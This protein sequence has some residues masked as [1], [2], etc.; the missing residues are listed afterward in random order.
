[1]VASL[2]R[3]W[4][5]QVT[6][7]LTL[8]SGWVEVK[9]QTTVTPNVV[10]NMADSTDFDSGG[11]SSDEPTLMSWTHAIAFNRKYSAGNIYDPGQELIR[12]CVGQFGTLARIG[13]QWFDRL[14]GPEANKG[15]A[16]VAW[17]SSSGGVKD[18]ENV[19]VTFTGTDQALQP[20]ANPYLTA[21]VPVIQSITPPSMGATSAPVAIIGSGFTGTVPVTGVK[22]N[23]VNATSFNVIN[24]QLII[25]QLPAGAAGTTPVIV[26]NAAGAS[27][28]FNYL[29]IV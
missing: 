9:G 7:D 24:D 29:R 26:T 22:F 17:K 21:L 20:I 25:A 15:V 4:R 12:A 6:S 5:T 10:P 27:T 19:G 16:T 3:K 1:M 18:L 23:A 14:G 13:V 8:A 2:A 28:A 11:Y